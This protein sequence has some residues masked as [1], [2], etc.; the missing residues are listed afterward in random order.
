MPRR[1]SPRVEPALLQYSFDG[2]QDAKLLDCC[3]Y[4]YLASSP[5][6]REAVRH[7]R[8]GEQDPLAG[9]VILLFPVNIFVTLKSNSWPDRPYL[10]TP[11]A[12][13]QPHVQSS[14]RQENLASWVT[15]STHLYDVGKAER[16][17]P[18]YVPPR[19]PL[20]KLKKAFGDLIRRDYPHLLAK[21][22][23][24]AEWYI[25]KRGRGSRIEQARTDLKALSAWRLNKQFGYTAKEA[26]RLMRAHRLSTYEVDSAF[27][28]AVTRAA[29][30]IAGL[31]ER[32]R[33]YAPK[34]DGIK[35]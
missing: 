5:L 1:N 2:C 17:V 26:I 19:I 31:E 9:A 15:P 20:P 13:S 30:K 12:K 28:R 7:W 33:Q 22:P 34:H 29:Q 6:I 25:R 35:Q 3:W 10:D 24:E 27:Y 14:R 18:V 11:E 4:E 16:V 32:L 8:A 23:L 21:Q